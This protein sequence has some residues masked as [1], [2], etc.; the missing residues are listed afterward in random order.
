[1][2]L[3]KNTRPGLTAL[4]FYIRNLEAA[5]ERGL[6]RRHQNCRRLVHPQSNDWI[7]VYSWGMRHPKSLLL[8]AYQITLVY[9]LKSVV[10][11]S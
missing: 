1:M 11:E 6:R 4:F 3:S 9:S 2:L 5:D 8:A 7:K 10:I